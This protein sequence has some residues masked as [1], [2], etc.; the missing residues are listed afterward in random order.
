VIGVIMNILRTRSGHLLAIAVTCAAVAASV[1]VTACSRPQAESDPP[2]PQVVVDEADANLVA[3]PHPEQFELTTAA[4][5]ETRAEVQAP[6]VIAPDVA[7]TVPVL[8]LA[9]GRVIDVRARLG[10]TVRKGQT[11]VTIQSA[12]VSQAR[13][14]LNKF[15]ADAELARRS[16][17]RARDLSEHDAL[18]TKDLEAAINTDA[19]AQA[20]RRTARD[21]LEL[22]TGSAETSGS[23]IVELKAP[24]GGV[25][26]E[27]NVTGSAGVKSLDNSP[28]LFTI[29]DLSHVWVLCDLNENHLADVRVD[30][31]ATVVLNAYLDRPLHARVANVS[32]VLDPATRTAKVRL[33]LANPDG[34]LRPGMFATVTFTAQRTEK[35]TVVPSTAVLRLRDRAWVF[36]PVDDQHFRR[37]EIRTGRERQGAQEVL[38]GLTPGSRIVSNALQLSSASSQP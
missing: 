15:E 22:L 27:Q 1:V 38:A 13:A 11:L 28:N 31:D 20:D 36:T 7:R 17:D 33:E 14:D 29:A 25:I 35:V 2:S 32:R 18:A 19:K 34:L 3:V 10:D 6:G 9:G 21:R 30:D 12:D 24:V 4:E 23:P 37:M 26:T 16:L 5:R 8:S